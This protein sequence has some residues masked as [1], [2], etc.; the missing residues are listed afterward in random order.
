[1]L[2][3]LLFKEI[4][5]LVLMI[6]AGYLLVKSKIAKS[7]DSHI[8]SII[9]IYLVSPMVLI[10]A[11]QVEYSESI[12]KGFL[13]ATCSALLIHIA[14]II[15]TRIINLVFKF[16]AV[17]KA[18]IIYS[19]AGNLIIPL[20][21]ALFG[22]EWIIYTSAYMMV[23]QLFF[24]TH[25]LSLMNETKSVDIKK[26]LSNINI[27]AIF[28]GIFM[29]LFQIQLPTIVARSVSGIASMIAPISMIMLGMIFA[30]A[31]WKELFSNNRLYLIVSLKLVFVPSI[32]LI[33][34]RLSHLSSFVENGHT[35]ILISLLATIAPT[36]AMVTQIS[37]LYN[38]HPSYAAS[39]NMLS[40]SLSILSMPILIFFYNLPF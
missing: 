37:R 22:Q 1:M 7:E 19:N 36:A 35:I 39:I 25:C 34:L 17:E 32:I 24:W 14:L 31:K 18:S 5:V 40:T 29:F 9:S 38:Q 6:I 15:L 30:G 3:W 26:I 27:I 20:V 13:L 11:F 21:L 4:V 12:L 2:A 23:Q 8:L 10:N 16:N 28:I 33:L